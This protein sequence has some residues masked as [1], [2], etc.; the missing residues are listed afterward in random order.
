MSSP[1]DRDRDLFEEFRE[2]YT[3]LDVWAMLCPQ[4]EQPK[5]GMNASPFRDDKT[6]SFSIY[7]QGRRFKDHGHDEHA[8]TAVDFAMIAL[9][10]DISGVREWILERMGINLEDGRE[11]ERQRL[12]KPPRT[13]ERIMFPAPLVKGCRA[14]CEA[15]ARYREGVTAEGL[16]AAVRMGILRFCDIRGRKCY[17]VTDSTARCAEIRD[18]KGRRWGDPQKGSKAYKLAMY[19]GAKSWL[20]GAVGLVGRSNEYGVIVTEGAPDLLAAISLQQRYQ[21]EA[22]WICTALLGAGIKTLN[23]ECAALL[24]GRTVR[25][26]PDVGEQGEKMARTWTDILVKLGCTVDIM[27][28]PEGMPNGTDLCNIAA[29]LDPEDLFE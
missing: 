14:T 17:V 27:E 19:P 5:V 3:V 21:G 23:P 16:E 26:V 28:M 8:G 24:K 25:L 1:R 10:T 9:G 29:E 13:P 12:A 11:Q 4:A 18:I 2:R 15:M 20:I 6:P 7:E 22:K